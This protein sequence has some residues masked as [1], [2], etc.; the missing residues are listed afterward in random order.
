MDQL[1]DAERRPHRGHLRRG[2]A[3]LHLTPSAISQRIKALENQRRPRPRATL[4]TGASHRIRARGA[5]SGRQLELLAG[6]TA[7]EL[8][9]ADRRADRPIRIPI[10]VNA[11]SLESWVMP[12]LARVPAGITFDLHREDEDTPPDCCATAR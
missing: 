9:D 10:A 4:E 12:A 5:A 7:R 6:D 2:R 3:P 11:D 8:G 1:R